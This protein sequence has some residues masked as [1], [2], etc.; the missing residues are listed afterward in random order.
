L[1]VAFYGTPPKGETS[2]TAESGQ[3]LRV[4]YERGGSDTPV[5]AETTEI[6]GLYDSYLKLQAAAQCR[7]LMGLPVGPVLASRL[8]RGEGQWK[9]YVNRS[10]SSG[11]ADKTPVWTPGRFRNYTTRPTRFRAP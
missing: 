8:G 1:A 9:K 6:G 3:R 7:E 4:W 5:L 2:W 10:R 11:L